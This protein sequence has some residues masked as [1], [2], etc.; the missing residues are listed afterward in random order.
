MEKPFEWLHSFLSERTNCVVF[1]TSRS[2]WVPAPFGVPQGSVL[3]PL[4]YIIYTSG[5]GPLLSF[6]GLLHQLYA[7]DVQAYTHCFSDSALAATQL[8]CRAMDALAGWL[9]S[10]HLLLN[11]AKTQFIWLGARS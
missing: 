9:A 4:L 3:G 11:T 5:I 7:D 10:N 6:Y 8:M 2:A 1:G